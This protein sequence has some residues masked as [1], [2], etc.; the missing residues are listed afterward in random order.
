MKSTTLLACT[1]VLATLGGS[2]LL[3]KDRTHHHGP[4]R[5]DTTQTSA[6][7]GPD[8]GMQAVVHTAAQGEQ[9]YGWQYFCD[10]DHA[11][12]VVISPDGQYY[13]SRGKGL[14]WVAGAQ[15]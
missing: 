13:L 1:L 12:A 11:R 2:P 4:Q 3:A 15:D 8:R 14:R 7:D 9:G 5:Q 10:P 6:P